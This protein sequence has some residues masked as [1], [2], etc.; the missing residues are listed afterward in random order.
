L[1]A[2]I[3]LLEA[4]LVI[5]VPVFGAGLLQREYQQRTMDDL[6]LTRL[7]GA[8]IAVGKLTTVVGYYAVVRLCALPVLALT[9]LFG[10]VSPWEILCAQLLLLATAACTGAVGLYC[11]ARYRGLAITMITTI[12]FTFGWVF[13]VIPLV[14]FMM[15]ISGIVSVVERTV[16]ERPS[17]R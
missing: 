16:R 7:G 13:L 3:I 15:V 11:A 12:L 6:L 2:V 17:E 9:F 4:A 1:F 5:M 10:G 8:E 14:V